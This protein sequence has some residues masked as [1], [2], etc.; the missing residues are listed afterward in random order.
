MNIRRKFVN[1]AGEIFDWR[2]AVVT[3][4]E[5]MTAMSAKSLGYG[6]RMHIDLR[7]VVILVNKEWAV[8]QKWREDITV[9]RQNI[10]ARYKYNHVHNAES[11]RKIFRILATVDAEQDQQKSKA[12]GELADMVSQGTIMQLPRRSSD[13]RGSCIPLMDALNLGD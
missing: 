1:I 12:T 9:A 10:I 3:K 4:V 2:E 7:A 5:Q 6:V 13:L 8:Q 11:I